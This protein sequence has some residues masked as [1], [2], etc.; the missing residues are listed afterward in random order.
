MFSGII[1]ATSA[2]LQIRTSG[3]IRLVT[4]QRPDSF[5]D[6]KQG[7]SIACDG[8]CLTAIALE[9]DSFT[10]QVMH[11]TLDKTTAGQ[12]ISGRNL[13]LERALQL[14]DRLDGHWVMGHIDRKAKF[15]RQENRGTTAYFHFERNP[16]D[17][18]LMIPQ[19]SIAINGISL[20]IASLNTRDFSV[21]LIQHTLEN[22]T[23]NKLRA[24]DM[25]NLEFDAL[26]K[27]VRELT[28]SR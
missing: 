16:Q 9:K 20:T 3:G 18:G 5:T 14:G 15:L 27:Y 21:A 1:E 2:I 4:I 10:V 7:C 28:G 24:G 13:N 22:T 17:A 23:L 19:G 6:L 25:V 12:W 8:I 11:E 26:G